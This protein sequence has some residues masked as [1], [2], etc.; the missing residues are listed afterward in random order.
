[1]TRS[2]SAIAFAAREPLMPVYRSIALVDHF[3]VPLPPPSYARARVSDRRVHPEPTNARPGAVIDGREPVAA[4]ARRQPLRKGTHQVPY[5]VGARRQASTAAR[6]CDL[7][8][9][10]VRGVT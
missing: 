9:G 8:Q 6:S 3:V 5:V 7:R 2:R 4:V 10:G 1:M